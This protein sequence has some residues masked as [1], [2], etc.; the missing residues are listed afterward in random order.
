[1]KKP[2]TQQLRHTH[3]SAGDGSS[4]GSRLTPIQGV[5]PS[6]AEVLGL[7]IHRKEFFTGVEKHYVERLSRFVRMIWSIIPVNGSDCGKKLSADAAP[8]QGPDIS[9]VYRRSAR[10]R[11]IVVLVPGDTPGIIFRD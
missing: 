7:W 11:R 6:G 3:G 4:V 8:P 2:R 1:M 5:G 10:C 9:L